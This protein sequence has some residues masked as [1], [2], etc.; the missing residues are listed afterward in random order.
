[1]YLSGQTVTP[2]RFTCASCGH[3]HVV[4]PGTIKSLPVC[5]RCQAEEWKAA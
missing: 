1:M 4:P 3:Q 2:G 5:P